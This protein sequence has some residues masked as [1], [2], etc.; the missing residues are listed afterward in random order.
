MGGAY[1]L[2]MAVN[3]AVTLHYGS[4]R[5]DANRLKVG[6]ALNSQPQLA[7]IFPLVQLTNGCKMYWWD[8]VFN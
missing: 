6:G 1:H 2:K 4:P 8:Y 5:P 3:E 7:T